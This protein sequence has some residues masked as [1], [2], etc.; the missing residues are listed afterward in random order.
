MERLR[1]VQFTAFGLLM[2]VQSEMVSATCPLP[3][4]TPL[5]P[6]WAC[7][8]TLQKACPRLLMLTLA[9]SSGCLKDASEPGVSLASACLP[10]F[11]PLSRYPLS[12]TPRTPLPPAALLKENQHVLFFFSYLRAP[13]GTIP[14]YPPRLRSTSLSLHAVGLNKHELSKQ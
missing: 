4:S 11:S 7:G 14:P 3:L 2:L 5:P 13:A 9:Q 6:H 10:Y 8:S 1:T 12:H